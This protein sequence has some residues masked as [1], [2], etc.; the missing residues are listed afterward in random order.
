MWSLS[1][2]DNNGSPYSMSASMYRGGRGGR[3]RKAPPDLPSLLLDAR[4][5]Y[6]GMPVSI[7]IRVSFWSLFWLRFLYHYTTVFKASIFYTIYLD[8]SLY[9]L[10]RLYQLWQNL[11]LLNLCGWIMITLPS[12]FIYISIRLGL[13]WVLIAIVLKKFL[14]IYNASIRIIGFSF[15]YF[16]FRMRR[17]RLW[18]QKL[19]LIP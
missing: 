10:Y 15:H 11:F 18:D 16:W 5:C 7:V 14:V 3:P 19:M 1:N 13:R 9:D 17:M 4:I 8:V 12:L 2:M 6:L